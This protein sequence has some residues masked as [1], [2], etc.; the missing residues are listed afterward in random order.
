MMTMTPVNDD[1]VCVNIFIVSIFVRR[2]ESLSL[3]HT[4]KLTEILGIKNAV[5]M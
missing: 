4:V 3:V 2:K 1:I 5:A